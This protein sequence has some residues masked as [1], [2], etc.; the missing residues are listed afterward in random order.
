V[1]VVNSTSIDG[2]SRVVVGG[3]WVF[4]VAPLGHESKFDG[5]FLNGVVV[6]VRWL[7][8]NS[9]GKEGLAK[10][11]EKINIEREL[12][13][14]RG[15]VSFVM[16]T[17]LYRRMTVRRLNSAQLIELYCRVSQSRFFA[18]DARGMAFS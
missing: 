11:K 14:G 8:W 16:A 17:L 7:L 12:C 18:G 3:F 13:A 10:R 15:L 2:G 5:G 6:T 9:Q 4:W 1:E